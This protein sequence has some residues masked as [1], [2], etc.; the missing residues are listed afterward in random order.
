MNDR[1]LILPAIAKAIIAQ[2]P[3]TLAYDKLPLNC[4]KYSTCGTIKH[5]NT[6]PTLPDMFKK[7]VKLGTI[8]HMRVTARINALLVI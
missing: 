7:S 1:E 4:F 3:I 2:H 6:A 5:E 8:R